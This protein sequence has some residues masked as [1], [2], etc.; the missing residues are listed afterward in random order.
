MNDGFMENIT[1]D[2][3]RKVFGKIFDIIVDDECWLRHVILVI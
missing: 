3:N 1:V 2:D